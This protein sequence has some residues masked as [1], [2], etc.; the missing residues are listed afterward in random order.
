MTKLLKIGYKG[1]SILVEI[2]LL[3]FIVL[4]FAIRFPVFQTFLAQKASS[5]LSSELETVVRID[6]LDVAF[7]DHIYLDGVY[8]EDRD[9]DTLAFL[10]QVELNV[11]SFDWGFRK[12]ELDKIALSNGKIN[13]IKK[14]G[15]EE[16][17]YAFIEDFLASD[18]DTPPS[19]R[20]SPKIYLSN[21]ILN[22]ID[23]KYILE[24]RQNYEHGINFNKLDL[25]KVNLFV[26]NLS[27][28][29]EHISGD[30]VHLKAK[31]KSG[32]VLDKFVAHFE[33]DAEKL[34][35]KQGL[36][37]TQKSRIEVPNLIFVSKTYDNYNYFE[38]SVHMD[39]RL[40]NT[41]VSLEDIAYFAPDL[42]GMNQELFLS[43]RATDFVYNL[44]IRDLYLE[45]GRETVLR[46]NFELPDF[47]L[48][49]YNIPRQQI[50]LLQTSYHD[51]QQFRLPNS[52][53]GLAQWITF[54]QD[55]HTQRI[56]QEAAVVQVRNVQLSGKPEDF[57]LY[58]D[59]IKSGFGNVSLAGGMRFFDDG[60]NGLSCVPLSSGI[61]VSNLDLAKISGESSLGLT[62]G[63]VF[64]RGAALETSELNFYDI[65]AQFAYMDINGYRY[66]NIF[67][68]KGRADTREFDGKVHIHDP[69]AK[70]SYEGLVRYDEREE[71]TGQLFLNYL[72]FG[73]IGIDDLSGIF[74]SGLVETN[75]HG[76]SLDRI[77]GYAHAVDFTV[78]KD[79]TAYTFDKLNVDVDRGGV[80]DELRID[81]DVLQGRVEG[82]LEFNQIIKAV[83]HEFAQILPII[84]KD[85]DDVNFD[86]QD[87]TRFEFTIKDA[88]SFLDVIYKDLRVER[89][90]QL[91]GALNGTTNQ[92][93]FNF[94]SPQIR[95]QDY[96]FTG[97]SLN[98]QIESSSVN[99]N[100]SLTRFN[101]NDSLFF[102]DIIFSAMGTNAEFSSTLKWDDQPNQ[103]GRLHWD[104]QVLSQNE[105]HFALTLGEFFIEEQKW[106]LG[107]LEEWGIK[108]MVYYRN[109]KF[110]IQD[111]MFA[112]GLQY[113]SASGF[114][115][116]DYDDALEVFVSDFDL[117]ILNSLFLNDIQIEGYASGDFRLHSV[118]SN[119]IFEG[120]VGIEE[121]YLNKN[122]LG[123][124][125]FESSYN[126]ADNKLSIAGG[127][128]NRNISKTRSN[129]FRG[130][131]YLAKT[132]LGQTTPDRLDFEF[133]FA[134]MDISFANAFVDEELAS[135]IQGLI[136][137]KLYVTGSSAK[138]L[139]AGK[140]ELNNGGAKIG[141]L[142]T[143]YRV[144]GPINIT[145][146]GLS[147]TGVPLIDQENN[148]A[149]LSASIFHENFSKW[150]YN[151]FLDL[152]RDGLRRDPQNNKIPAKLERFMAL[153]T[154]YK[155]G[156][157][158]YGRGYVTGNLNIYGTD[159]LVDITANVKSARGTQINFP[160]YGR[161]DIA[162]DDFVVF[163]NNLDTTNLTVE[164]KLDFTGVRLNLNIEANEDARLRIIFDERTGD[165]ISAVGRGKFQI[166]L[167]E[168]NDVSMTGT[169]EV[170]Q[171]TYNFALGI[172]KKDFIIEPG[173]TV[174]WMGDPYE[175]TLNVRTYYLVEA[176]IDDIAVGIN[177]ETEFRTNP[178]DQIY[179]YLALKDRLSQPAMEFDIEAP[180]A[181]DAG[182]VA[183][184]RVRSD[185]DELTK[186]FFSLLLFRQ[187]QPLRGTQ[188]TA[189]TRGSNALNELV[190]N[191]INAVLN[192]VSGNYDLRVKLNDDETANQSTY[193]LGFS[194]TFLDDRLLVSGSFGVSQMRSGANPG[195]TNSNPLIGDINIE[196]KLNRS[197][198]FRVNAF[199]RS[200]QFTVIQQHNLGPFTQ[201]VG[202]YYQENFSSWDDF[203]M[204][205]Y[206][207]DLFRPY[208]QRR[209]MGLDSRLMRLPPLNPSDS[210]PKPAPADTTN[211]NEEEQVPEVESNPNGEQPTPTNPP[212]PPQN[213]VVEEEE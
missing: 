158:F 84:V 190:A 180:K 107:D 50:F 165:E 20:P 37:E 91:S 196:Y 97:I 159:E 9:G 161:G 127:L 57:N 169:Y 108:P 170:S 199:N 116:E 143:K 154:E 194:T 52:S 29:D 87:F 176:N 51:L 60:A 98:N 211:S 182:R 112:S 177:R 208:N 147:I 68:N 74:A 188:N 27:I 133:D 44:K 113:V 1:T 212:T 134:T 69:N 167:N 181:T 201:G 88:N 3:L 118:L 164:K 80:Y 125:D 138:P 31:E 166:A 137:G 32:F 144:Q 172:V 126:D 95:Y 185:Y 200:N 192:Q 210:A 142:G 152:D 209:Y 206:T 139:V 136:E 43:G 15:Q 163:I 53:S 189:S 104:T 168:L 213:A 198:T 179:C 58:A 119:V 33:F 76:F 156:E 105:I 18:K 103:G 131:Y 61:Q 204:A 117:D 153:N 162:E 203:Q 36:I 129:L 78:S 135:E 175:A 122:Y 86:Y 120:T 26:E 186:Q 110:E 151:V 70:L 72:D 81:S 111:L 85:V 82:V 13:L 35:I 64:F 38:D 63:N 130:D 7:F 49:Q 12:I 128:F 191:Q 65:E 89:G 77:Y 96:V 45:T 83:Q 22:D 145:N 71:I 24:Y 121:L 148:A 79:S 160:M 115:S 90:T 102:Q 132:I 67:V 66:S 149:I 11:S 146:Y 150:E 197:G 59:Q 123:I 205:Q 141:L 155:E 195:M 140:L 34:Q 178:R 187:F 184:N 92:F 46:G 174:K 109:N 56:L 2:L 171:G 75:L 41:I 10:E 106:S 5:W 157:I 4:S 30:I 23:F 21:L 100:Y 124:L 73:R 6:R 94:S 19:T 193:E 8:L 40:A 183:I 93:T 39:I 14:L 25:R 202:I 62:S 101:L 55:I 99:A 16:F 54:P 17:N 28:I 114:I 47:R 173:S 42:W 207:L 48:D